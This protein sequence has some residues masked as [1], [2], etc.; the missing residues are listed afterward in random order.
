MRIAPLALILTL[1]AAP[2]FAGDYGSDRGHDGWVG[3]QGARVEEH[4]AQD[5]GEA[6][7]RN[8]WHARRDAA[9]GDYEG[10]EHAQRRAQAAAKDA[11]RHGEAARHGRD[12]YGYGRNT[13]HDNRH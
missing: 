13:E 7:N 3:Q 4:Q 10:A 12:S 11:R 8:A 2:A 9:V 6:A 1:G 5:A